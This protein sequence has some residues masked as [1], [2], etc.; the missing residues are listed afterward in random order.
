MS[1]LSEV[2][3]EDDSFNQEIFLWGFRWSRTCKREYIDK[4]VEVSNETS[5]I[6]KL[7]KLIVRGGPVV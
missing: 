7:A 4:R 5:V 2:E 1:S 6:Q 3:Q